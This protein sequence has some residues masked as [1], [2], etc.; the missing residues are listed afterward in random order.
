VTLA[1]HSLDIVGS[2]LLITLIPPRGKRIINGGSP[3]IIIDNDKYDIEEHP[4]GE[5]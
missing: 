5:V 2:Q 1:C 4:T 3:T